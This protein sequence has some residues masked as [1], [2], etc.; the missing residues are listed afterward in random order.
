MFK[1][2]FHK[3][4][5]VKNPASPLVEGNM[6]KNKLTAA[7][8]DPRIVV[9]YGIPSTASVLAF[10]HVQRLLAVATLDGR[11]K[12]IGGDNIEALLVSPKQ[13]P[14]KYLEFLQ[15]QGL[16][17]SVSNDNDIQVWDLK[18]RE[19]AST[20]QWN[21]NVTAFS[22]MFGTQ[23]IYIG[24]EQGVVSVVKFDSLEGKLL[25]LPY[26]LSPDFVAEKA[27][28]QLPDHNSV[29]GLSLQPGPHGNRLLV[30][31]DNGVIV[32][33]DTLEVEV[34]IV[35][36]NNDL[37]LMES[38]INLLDK[39][40][41]GSPDVSSNQEQVEKEI[42][43]LCWASSNGSVLAVGY[44]DGDIML[45]NLSSSAHNKDHRSVK[46]SNKVVKLQLA[47]GERRL[48]V[49]VLHWSA[50]ITMNDN[51]GLL[52]VYGGDEIGSE[53]VLTILRLDWSSGLD[54]LK[55]IGRV[56]LTLHGSF[57]DMRLLSKAGASENSNCTLCVL[58]NP[59]QLLIYDDIYSSSIMSEQDNKGSIHSL[60]FRTAV[61]TM[62]PLMTVGQLHSVYAAEKLSASLAKVVSGVDVK[63]AQ[64][65]N[66]GST[67]WPLTGGVP[68]Q[69]S[70]DHQIKRVYI[71]GYHDG[72][73]RIWD[74]TYP[75]LTFISILQLKLGDAQMEGLTAPVS[76]LDFCSTSSSLIVGNERGLVWLYKLVDCSDE[77]IVHL[78][79]EDKHEVID[80]QQGVPKCMAVFSILKS[81]VRTLKFLNCG[82]KAAAGYECGQVALFDLRSFTVL[83]LTDIISSPSSPVISIHLSPPLKGNSKGGGLEGLESENS[84]E[85]GEEKIILLTKNANIVVLGTANG[86]ICNT[87]SIDPEGN[88][89]AISIHFVGNTISEEVNSSEISKTERQHPD[90]ESQ[91]N[92][93]IS[94]DPEVTERKMNNMLVLL[95]LEKSLILSRISSLFQVET[96]YI[97]KI[98]L[99]NPCCWTTVFEEN[100][101][102]RGIA[103]LYRTGVIEIRSF[104]E[105][106]I[107]KECSLM[108]ILRWS[109]KKNMEKTL[110]STTSGQLALGN[111]C[112]FSVVSLL[113]SENIFRIP[114]SLPSLHDEVLAAAADAAIKFSLNAK[115]KQVDVPGILGGLIKGIKA[116]KSENNQDIKDI[117]EHFDSVF[118][119]PPGKMTPPTITN[120]EVVELELQ[121][122][123][124]EIDEPVVIPSTSASH[125][126][127]NDD[128][129]K[130]TERERLFGGASDAKPK[131]RTAE[132]I[133]A[134][135]RKPEATAAAAARAR[136]RLVQRQEKLENLS[137]RTEELQNG[138]EDFASMAQELARRMEKRNK[139]WKL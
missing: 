17:I 32:L 90:Q 94:P 66:I 26:S 4:A 132:E 80:H 43:S 137:K 92:D 78:I 85:V 120:E 18:H 91:P 67:K 20:L 77:N 98:D 3:N 72:S 39:E 11:I 107:V 53:E 86:T 7:D 104:P 73:V 45:W 23:F 50:D 133:A 47:S 125:G 122:D 42:S 108:S 136:E 112:E 51:G 102:K 52:F 116:G 128:K 84:E 5:A 69:P 65:P 40:E 19:I 68:S 75:S 48:P 138:A 12:I 49:I 35:R 129:G 89:T 13:L 95:S 88:S 27:D 60:P 106:E 14:F 2:L 134:K 41:S 44:V 118:S 36:G 57:A 61:P 82:A 30:A 115:K 130:E 105:L 34:V 1:K 21:C 87:G 139:W 83:F 59:G 135:Y 81:P 114:E 54:S 96:N 16:L 103:I 8:L 93:R 126:S 124:I 29:V 109:F 127:K 25:Q 131:A 70:A 64:N 101:E 100:C 28:I 37:Q 63:A 121:I 79:L 71:G 9:H 56:D 6:P 33:W 46:S 110:T 38:V 15:N 119:R 123:D 31:Y 62:E 117:V 10:D 97:Q 55:C 22:V 58:T 113:A 99:V 74:A 24:D 111:G 76:A